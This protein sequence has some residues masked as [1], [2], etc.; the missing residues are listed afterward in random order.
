M[1]LQF[2]RTETV[3]KATLIRKKA[4]HVRVAPIVGQT[5]AVTEISALVLAVM[6]MGEWFVVHRVMETV[7]AFPRETEM[8]STV[9]QAYQHLGKMDHVS[10]RRP[11]LTLPVAEM[12]ALSLA[13]M[14]T[15]LL[16]VA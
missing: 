9:K 12:V 6:E 15:R 14:I 8:G 3:V 1:R 4:T 2:V 13:E 10:A 11:V 7:S 5:V 16:G